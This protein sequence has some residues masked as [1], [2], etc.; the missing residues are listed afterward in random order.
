MKPKGTLMPRRLW[1]RLLGCLVALLALGAAPASAYQLF[2][3]STGGSGVS[4]SHWTSLPIAV[5]VDGG[6]TDI[7]AEIQTA[8]TTWND[9]PTAQDVWATATTSATDFKGSNF[10]TAWGKLTGD[11]SHEAIFDED[12]SALMALGLA[13]ASVN[14]YGPRHELVSGGTATIDDMYLIINGTRNDFVR[15]ATE[16]HELGHTIGLAHSS[17]GFY[18]GKP[19]ALSPVLEN[20]VPTMHPYS[21]GGGGQRTS[22]EADDRAAVSENYP[23]G[24]FA[25][26]NGVLTG[27][28]TRCESDDPVLGANV[29]AINTA[30]PAIQLTRVTGFDGATD[31]SYTIRGVP[32]GTYDIIVEPLAGDSDYVDRLAMFTRID[33]DFSQ[34]F[35]TGEATE[36][37]CEGGDDDTMAKEDVAVA[38]AGSQTAN[39]KVDDALLAFVIDTTGSMGPE[40]GGVRDALTTYISTVDA[41]PGDFPR[42]AILTFDDSAYVETISRDPAVLQGVVNGLFASGGGDCPEAS[43]AGLM[44]AG[45]LLARN[46]RAILATDA[47]SRSDGPSRAAVE[48]LYASKG[49]RLSTILSG[50]CSEDFRGKKKANRPPANRPATG[51]DELPPVD[52]LGF[53]GAI[54]TFSELTAFSGGLF[55][56]QPKSDLFN[57]DGKTKY[58]NTIANVAISSVT[59]AVAGLT[60]SDVPQGATIEAELTG[61]N[62]DFRPASTVAVSGAGVT[63]NSV[64][65]VSPSE[66]IVRLTATPGAGLGFRDV[67]VTT[68][69]GSD[70][71]IAKGIGS[72]Q[73]VAAPVDPTILSVTPSSGEVGSTLDTTILAANTHF[74]AGTSDAD[75]GAGVTVNSLTVKS[76]TEAVANVTIADGADIGFRDVSV[77]TAAEV[78]FENVPGPFLVTAKAPA[79][80]TLTD[81]SPKSGAR[82]ATVDVTLT[83]TNTSFADGVSTASVTGTG[84]DVLSTTVSSPTEL[85][86]KLKI[87]PNA[88]LGFRD[89]IVTTGGENAALLDGFE[90]TEAAATPTP[91]PG[92]GGPGA[93]ATATA[94]ATAPPGGTP[95]TDVTAPRAGLRKGARG[96]RVKRRR[97][98][99]RGTAS[100]TGCSATY[101]VPGALRRV[102]VAISRKAGRKCRSVKASGKLTKRR[103]CGKRV[104]L[105]AK[106]TSSWSLKLKRRLPRGRYTI[107]VRARDRAGNV[108]GKPAVRKLRVR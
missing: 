46:G 84:V 68:T 81:A 95:C 82:G 38:A 6:P 53:E 35:Y 72:L 51:G 42:T 37:D 28:V 7:T 34:E 39:I 92:G 48:G 78:A 66:L 26:T 59:P 58:A 21:V 4:P 3:Q 15:A 99:L 11:G 96:V 88:A 22:L 41:L 89:V 77:T 106:G 25:T 29:R 69:S 27:K 2:S 64:T 8:L 49:V 20:D 105:K 63:V 50:S 23:E 62:T 47:D 108:Q 71:Q 30:D 67:T 76:P 73:V 31:G 60:P 87:A 10:G 93:T 94:T 14:G 83:G 24:S 52:E 18:L 91:T 55:S 65:Y 97:L 19:E 33:T 70:T 5:T 86:A 74:A 54:R 98:R 107:R 17:V 80:P 16:V 79:V 13:P 56:F 57:P 102:E 44:A 103:G 101:S 90:V 104:W 9:V 1:S 85:V 43:N 36:S 75:L 12:G 61:S 32:P 40:I 100:D 45:R